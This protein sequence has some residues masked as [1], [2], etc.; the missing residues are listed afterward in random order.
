VGPV[1]HAVRAVACPAQS[2]RPRM[3]HPGEARDSQLRPF[4]GTGECRMWQKRAP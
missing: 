3:P 4:H 1:A 2:S